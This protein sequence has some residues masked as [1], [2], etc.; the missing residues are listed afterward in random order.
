MGLV[1][2]FSQAQLDW[3]ALRAH[4][5]LRIGA[6]LLIIAPARSSISPCC[7]RW[8]SGRATSCAARSKNLEAGRSAAVAVGGLSSMLVLA[9]LLVRRSPRLRTAAAVPA[10]PA[11]PVLGRRPRGFGR[12]RRLRRRR[13]RRA[14]IAAPREQRRRLGRRLPGGWPAWLPAR[15]AGRA[16]RTAAALVDRLPRRHRPCPGCPPAP[17]PRPAPSPQTSSPRCARGSPGSGSAHRSSPASAASIATG[18]T[19]P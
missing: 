2:W 14:R 11:A 10:A 5:V 1:A 15:P 4:P 8:A 18:C 9:V 17:A 6:L 16:G 7:S 13:L 12:R 19:R 3:A